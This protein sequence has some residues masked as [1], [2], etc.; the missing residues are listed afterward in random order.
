MSGEIFISISGF[1]TILQRLK[2]LPQEAQDAGV[3]ESN[4]Y[5]V[6]VMQKYPPRS[7]DP[8][9]WS[10]EKQRK[11]VMARLREQGKTY[12]T[13][14]QG[15]SRA[16]KTEGKGYKQ[17]ITN[18]TEYA[19]F[20]QDRYQIVGHQVRGWMTVNTMLKDKG[21]TILQKFDAGVKRALHKL[22]LN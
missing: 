10:S 18:D 9:V 14:T 12:Y 7:S 11:F 21:K 4:K 20:V 5:M 8:F 1:E 3:E 13:R 19:K 6:S 15:L 16:W 17:I 2:K 22:K